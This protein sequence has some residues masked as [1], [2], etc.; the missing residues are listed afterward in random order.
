MLCNICVKEGN[1]T[2]STPKVERLPCSYKSLFKLTAGIDHR[3]NGIVYQLLQQFVYVQ[4]WT[5]LASCSRP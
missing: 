4:I 5:T 1:M 3:S 2:V